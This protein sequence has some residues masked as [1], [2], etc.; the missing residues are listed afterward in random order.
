MNYQNA[1]AILLSFQ[2]CRDWNF[3]QNV[4]FIIQHNASTGL[5]ANRK[6]SEPFCVIMIFFKHTWFVITFYS[7]ILRV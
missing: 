3:K 2:A 7:Y 5:N 4:S 1:I 6:G